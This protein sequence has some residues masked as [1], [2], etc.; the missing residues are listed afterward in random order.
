M[1]F[2]RGAYQPERYGGRWAPAIIGFA[3]ATTVPGLAGDVGG[4]GGAS[5]V[6]VGQSQG[7]VT[8]AV[9]LDTTLLD[10]PRYDGEPGYVQVLRHEVG[11]LLGLAH[12]D[13]VTVLMHPDASEVTTWGPGDRAGLAALGAIPCQPDL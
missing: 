4:L 2:E 13:D 12:V 8:G 3:D 1:S 6:G 10:L 5:V 9:A 11:H 7:Y